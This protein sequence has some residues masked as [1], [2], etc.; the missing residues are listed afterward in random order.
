MQ[1]AVSSGTSKGS[2]FRLQA[3]HCGQSGKLSWLHGIAGIVV[4]DGVCTVE[5]EKDEF[6]RIGR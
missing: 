4:E 5:Y 6:H 3:D 1:E 2:A